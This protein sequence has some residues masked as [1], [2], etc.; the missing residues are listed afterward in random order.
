[1]RRTFKITLAA[2]FA[3]VPFIASAHTGH[4]EFPADHILHYLATPVH[5]VPIF[6]A[7]AAGISAAIILRKELAIRAIRQS[8]KK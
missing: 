4:S 6:M 2:V 8:S 3:A 5:A 1:M 7:V